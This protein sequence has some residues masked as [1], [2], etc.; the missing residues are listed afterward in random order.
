MYVDRQ[1][2]R[3]VKYFSPKPHDLPKCLT[4]TNSTDSGRV[5]SNSLLQLDEFYQC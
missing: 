1:K 4:D 3:H 2:F 5:S